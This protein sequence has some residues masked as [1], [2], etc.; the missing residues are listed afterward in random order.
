LRFVVDFPSL[1]HHH[2]LVLVIRAPLLICFHKLYLKE[3]VIPVE[4]HS[5]DVGMIINIGWQDFKSAFCLE[6]FP[7]SFQLGDLR[8]QV[9]P[10]GTLDFFRTGIK[11]EITQ[12]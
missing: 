8:G 1:A 6:Q 9:L 11:S 5:G 10:L 3:L 2:S 7:L 12:V 4:G